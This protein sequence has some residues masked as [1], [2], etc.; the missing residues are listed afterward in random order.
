MVLMRG[1]SF[2]TVAGS[3]GSGGTQRTTVNDE[4]TSAQIHRRRA[5]AQ[6]A[7][8]YIALKGRP[9]DVAEIDYLS[10]IFKETLLEEHNAFMMN[11]AGGGGGRVSS[12]RRCSTVRVLMRTAN[13]INFV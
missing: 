6:A 2:G 13:S 1:S 11:T 8:D 3:G 5:V 9:A 12:L 7:K 4:S 10:R